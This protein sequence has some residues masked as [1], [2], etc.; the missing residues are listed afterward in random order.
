M[1]K[2]INTILGKFQNSENTMKYICVVLVVAFSLSACMVGKKYERPATQPYAA[3]SGVDT[4]LK[5]DT[6]SLIAW[7]E[8]YKD[9]ELTKLIQTVLINNLDLLSAIA[10]V[11]E[12]RAIYG[13][14]KADLYPSFGY[15]LGANGNNLKENSKAT[16][17][18]IQG[19]TYSMLAT[20]NWEIDLFGKLRHQKASA[21][22]QFLAAQN[23][24]QAVRVSLIAEAATFYFILRDQ[25]N[26]LE[27]AKKTVEAQNSF[28]K[29]DLRKI[30]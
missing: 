25:D 12:A 13:I 10:R 28:F 29:T 7:T 8:V 15:S 21:W 6:A 23:N 16:G 24:A 2:V 20:M 3:Y 30:Q 27:I 19:Q 11:E 9:P 17:I 22:A 26:R 18:A 5:N 1:M 14:T 4:T